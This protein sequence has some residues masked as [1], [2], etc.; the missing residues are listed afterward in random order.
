MQVVEEYLMQ[1]RLKFGGLLLRSLALKNIAS[2]LA[3]GTCFFP[4]EV[5]R[6]V[7]LSYRNF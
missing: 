5:A 6:G 1:Q 4:L 7:N 2:F 3:G